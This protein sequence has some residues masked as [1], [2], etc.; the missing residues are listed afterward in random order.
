M[1]LCVY[2]NRFWS[3]LTGIGEASALGIPW[4]RIVHPDDRTAVER[5]WSEALAEQRTFTLE[6]N[7]LTPGGESRS[8]VCSGSPLRPEGDSSSGYV[9]TLADLTEQKKLEV[10]LR[11][12]HKLEAV[13]QLASG[14]A[15]EIN[16]PI[17]F[18]SDSI[19]FVKESFQDLEG[20]LDKYA[21]L[22]DAV[23]TGRV[24]PELLPAVR[25]AAE[26][27]DIAYLREQVPKAIDRTLDGVGRVAEIVRA[28]KE[29]AHPD[30]REKV[31]AD[32]NRSILSTLTVAR[33]ELKYVAEVETDL[34]ELPPVPCHPGDLNQ[35]VLNLLVNAAH[36]IADTQRGSGERGRITVRTRLEDGE[37]IISISDTGAGIPEQ[38]RDRIFEPFFT[39]K[40]V[41]KGTGQ[42]L[43]IA[44]SIVV[45]KHGGAISFETEVGRGTTFHLRL[46]VEKS[47]LVASPRDRE[48]PPLVG[49]S[50]L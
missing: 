22:E 23:A 39:T 50:R 36:A 27:A 2:T 30:Q 28:M 14:I 7:I 10:S 24:T 4:T 29:F 25:Q 35:V 8:V 34:G 32:L 40:P 45:D 44:R 48:P 5:T 19:H 15:H 17:Q 33:N 21:A 13:G 43:A 16:T 31:A 9:G 41:G 26:E 46:P 20:L 18:V 47:S 1:G 38:V 37:V 11:Q 12:A 42:G 3:D 49:A 6:F